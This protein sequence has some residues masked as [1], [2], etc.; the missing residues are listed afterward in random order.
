M[1]I[2]VRQQEEDGRANLGARFHAGTIC[3]E[4]NDA[5]GGHGGDEG[6]TIGDRCPSGI[7]VERNVREAISEDGEEEGEVTAKP[8]ADVQLATLRG[9]WRR[10]QSAEALFLQLK[11]GCKLGQA[12]AQRRSGGRLGGHVVCE[13]CEV[14]EGR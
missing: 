6:E 10:S 5:V 12:F 14:K 9:I 3:L 7:V 4:D 13:A 1:H 8:G 2:L 11:G